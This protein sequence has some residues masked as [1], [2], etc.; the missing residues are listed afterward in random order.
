M[1]DVNNTIKWIYMTRADTAEFTF[2]AKDDEGNLFHPTEKDKLI[3]KVSKKRDQEPF[4][5]IANEMASV[6]SDFWTIHIS[7][8]DT[9]ECKSGKYPYDVEIEQYDSSTGEFIS[10]STIIGKTEDLSPT[11]VLWGEI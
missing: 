8:E 4:L 2:S 3:F 10:R 5:V 7:P 1:I 11:L 9:E 6:E